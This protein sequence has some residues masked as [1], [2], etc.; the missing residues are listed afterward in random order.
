M[1]V[2]VS[3]P[4]LGMTMESGKIQ[5][6]LKGEG[7]SV[8]QDEP[9]L[10]IETEKATAEVTAPAPG[11]LLIRAQPGEEL[12]VGAVMAEVA[13]DRAEYERL[14][15]GGAGVPT[16]AGSAAP[17]GA[18]QPLPGAEPSAPAARGKVRAAP[19][20]RALAA[21]K[22]VD[23]ALV[24]GTGPEGRITKEDVL[25][26]VDAHATPDREAVSAPPTSVS[27]SQGAASATVFSRSRLVPR[28]GRRRIVAAKMM[29]AVHDAAQATHAMD[30]DAAT[31][32]AFRQELAARAG[33]L[34][35]VRVTLTD[36]IVALTARAVRTHPRLN[37][38]YTDEGDV[39]FEDVHMGLAASVEDDDLLVPVIR[40]AD[41]KSV[42]EIARARIDLLG[43][44]REGRLAPDDLTGST[45]TVSSLGMFGLDRFVAII[46]RPENA[47]L[48]VGAIGDRPWVHERQVVVRQVMSLTLT[49][50][51]RTIYGAEAARF[52]ATLRGYLEA[53]E[54]ALGPASAQS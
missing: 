33:R 44:A 16:E 50:D 24:T 36:V 28:T 9:I 3:M 19:V 14:R 10:A 30:V 42:V 17:G 54:T 7:A 38:R 11:L 29:E 40:E 43:R 12:P 5:V 37:S 13:G 46:N 22:G 53:P 23:L 49:Y 32:V 20:A 26:Y 34:A 21:E 25:A 51:H 41:R 48:A 35:G 39:L 8:Q 2:T 18:G 52:M 15:G 6:W 31:L 27:V 45:F 4:K 47:I 1:S